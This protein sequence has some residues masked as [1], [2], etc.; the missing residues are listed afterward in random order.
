MTPTF[1]PNVSVG[2]PPQ[3]YALANRKRGLSPNARVT[4][5]VSLW[6]AVVQVLTS[7]FSP[8]IVG[9]TRTADAL[10]GAGIGPP[11]IRARGER[12]NHALDGYKGI[13]FP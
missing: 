4:L 7:D 9:R 6:S 1:D 11:V 10:R 12:Q 2:N 8:S 3:R 5:A 13:Y